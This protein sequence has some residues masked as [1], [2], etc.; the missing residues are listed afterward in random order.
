[1]GNDDIAWM[2][3]DLSDAGEI[4]AFLKA[5]VLEELAGGGVVSEVKAEEV[6]DFESGAGSDHFLD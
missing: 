3:E 4:A 6:F 1:M 2:A 5:E